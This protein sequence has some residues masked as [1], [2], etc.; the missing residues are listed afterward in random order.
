MRR[1]IC[2]ALA[3]LALAACA[4]PESPSVEE[5]ASGAARIV[6]G[7]AD[8]THTAVVALLNPDH[9]G[10]DE[11]SGTIVQVCNGV[12][13]VLTAAHCCNSTQPTT[14][15]MASDYNVGVQYIGSANPPPPTYAVI[16]SSVQ[17]DHSYNGNSS[18]PIDDFCMLQ[19]NAPAN[20]AVIPVAVGN[21]NLTLG[22]TVE[23]S[24]FGTTQNNQN[25]TLREHASAPVDQDVTANYFQYSEGGSTHI[26]G[27][28]EG[29]SGGPALLPAG[30][31]Q[32]QQFVVGT[33]SYGD[34]NC[35]QY[36]VSM[37]VTSQTAP[38]G[39]IS[40]YL[41]TCQGGTTTTSTT[42]STTTTTTT[43]TASST[44]SGAV[45]EHTLCALGGPLPD[46]CH[47]CVTAVCMHDPACCTDAWD[48]TCA[49]DVALYCAGE[50]CSP[51]TGG[52]SATSTTATTGSGGAPATTTTVGTS[53]TATAGSSTSTFVTTGTSASTSTSQGS[54]T[55]GAGGFNGSPRSNDN[56]NQDGGCG[57]RVGEAPA[58]GGGPLVA[59]G[60]A[61]AG[62]LGRRR[63]GALRGGAR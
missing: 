15:V 42:A 39:F 53:T 14:V 61:L 21:D 56:S 55:D 29:D 1:T 46:G 27:P 58:P 48:Q 47:P 32:D 25:N 9:G 38:G 6:Y 30:A 37:R 12:A 26:G 44:G 20:T 52:A 8:T 35:R 7:T 4:E 3:S 49:D 19:F 59:L 31:P 33:T 63:R 2:L 45:C 60:L 62:V 13:S 54:T 24:G 28:C 16:A 34:A 43:T 10:Y 18:S 41:G 5:P 23:Y 22:T 36:G 50:S 57:C 11:C 51:G 40:S 17:W